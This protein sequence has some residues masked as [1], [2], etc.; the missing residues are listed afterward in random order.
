M[1]RYKLKTTF[2]GEPDFHQ[3]LFGSDT[4]VTVNSEEYRVIQIVSP[5]KYVIR[6]DGFFGG[7]EELIL[8][9]STFGGWEVRERGW[10]E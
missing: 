6:Q 5:T 8:E 10:L 7:G 4:Y 9:K 3:R 1:S 2:S